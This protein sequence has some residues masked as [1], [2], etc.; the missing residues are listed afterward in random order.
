VID[1]VFYTGVTAKG[2]PAP[3]EPSSKNA[4][5]RIAEE[6]DYADKTEELKNTAL[7]VL[8]DVQIDGLYKHVRVNMRGV[9]GNVFNILGTMISALRKA[10]A[11][12]LHIQVFKSWCC[13][14]DYQHVLRTCAEW[15]TI[16]DEPRNDM[17]ALGA[18]NKL[19]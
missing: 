10:G 16:V 15:V 2:L 19:S 12:D 14:G 17:S 9:D 8:A 1:H 11:P 3:R 13:S 6:V 18:F 4:M 7:R 5:E